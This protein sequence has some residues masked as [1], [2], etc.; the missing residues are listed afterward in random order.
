MKVTLMPNLT[1]ENAYKTTIDLCESLKKLNIN[2]DFFGDF[3]DYDTDFISSSDISADTDVIIAIGGDG[4]MIRAAKYALP[5]GIP[6]LGVNAGTLAF[7]ADLESNEM[8][9]LNKLLSKNYVIDERMVLDIKIYD[10]FNNIIYSDNCINDIVISRGVQIKISSFDFYCNDKFV[11]QYKADGIVIATPTGS[12]AYNL[13][14]GGPVIDPLIESLILTPICPHSFKQQTILF[15]S[16]SVL[17][18]VNP[19]ASGNLVFA[20]CDGNESIEFGYNYSAVIKKS[21]DKVKFIRLKND[22]FTD[23]LYKKMKN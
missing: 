18:I 16:D 9:L 3:S 14:A 2:Y 7:L 17:K 13:S 21:N 15:S 11:S 10:N 22:S 1:K 5:H 8:D 20:S 12:T 6:V 23:I 19:S 4:T